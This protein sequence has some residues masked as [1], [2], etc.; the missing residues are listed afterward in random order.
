MQL[1]IPMKIDYALPFP[2]SDEAQWALEYTENISP[3][4]Y[5]WNGPYAS[6]GAPIG[7]DSEWLRGLRCGMG[8]RVR[9]FRGHGPRADDDDYPFFAGTDIKEDAKSVAKAGS[10][11]SQVVGDAAQ[12]HDYYPDQ[13]TSDDAETAE[14]LDDNKWSLFEELQGLDLT[15]QTELL[16]ELDIKVDEIDE[17]VC[18]YDNKGTL[19]VEPDPDVVILDEAEEQSR[20]DAKVAEELIMTGFITKKDQEGVE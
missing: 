16:K 3:E 9:N 20:E 4:T 19:I 8:D 18:Y 12:E 10:Y 5:T 7:S 6:H 11:R 13:P 17:Y 1:E 2:A 15:D 14:D